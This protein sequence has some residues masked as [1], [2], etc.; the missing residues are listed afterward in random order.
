M[1]QWLDHPR[2]EPSTFRYTFISPGIVF[3]INFK[4]EGEAAEFATEFGGRVLAPAANTM[5]VG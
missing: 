1:R 2:V 4:T 3:R 5:A